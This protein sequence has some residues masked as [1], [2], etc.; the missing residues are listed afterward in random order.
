M[1]IVHYRYRYSLIRILSS[2]TRTDYRRFRGIHAVC[3]AVLSLRVIAR[4]QLLMF[5]IRASHDHIVVVTAILFVISQGVT[6]PLWK[7]M[8]SIAIYRSTHGCIYIYIFF[9]FY[10]MEADRNSFS[11]LKMPYLVTFSACF[12]FGRKLLSIFSTYCNL[13][14]IG[15][16]HF[17]LGLIGVIFL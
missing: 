10:P 15:L 3:R 2:L 13:P 8:E 12:V 17:Y 9:W 11:V 14:L 16:F 7:D 4:Y 1:D 5:E 6:P